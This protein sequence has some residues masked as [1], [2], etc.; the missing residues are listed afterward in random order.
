MSTL[1]LRLRHLTDKLSESAFLISE[2]FQL[3]SFDFFRGHKTNNTLEQPQLARQLMGSR[4]LMQNHW[5]VKSDC[6]LPLI[7]KEEI[8]CHMTMATG[9]NLSFTGTY[10]GHCS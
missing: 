8:Y 6:L 7:C 1:D 4:H 2:K 10:I 9:E 3:S 5:V